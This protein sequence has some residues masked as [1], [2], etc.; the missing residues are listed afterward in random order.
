[1]LLLDRIRRTIRTYGLADSG[2]GVVAA[3]SGGSDSVALAHL[4]HALEAAGEL[5]L[6]GLAH[7]NHRLRPSSAEEERFC[8]EQAEALQ[9][10]FLVESGDVATRARRE[11]RS[12][13]DAARA[14]RHEF[15]ARALRHF[16]ANAIALGHTRDD[17]AETFLLRLLRGAGARGLAAMHP[18]RGAVIRPL[19]E[20]RRAELR[21]FLASRGLSFVRDES[22]DDVRIPRNR[23]RVELVPLLERR[24][25]PA[26]VDALADAAEIARGE[27]EWMEAR[28]ADLA[29]RLLRREGAT[30][31]LEAADVAALPAALG[32]ALL[33]R[34][35]T[36]VSAG[37]PVSFAHVERARDLARTDG[38]PVDGPG[39]RMQ[40]VG[41][42]LVLTSR[43]LAAAGKPEPFRYPL[44]V[45]GEVVVPEAGCALVAET[46][47]SVGTAA[48]A[49]L[50]TPAAVVAQL[51][52][53]ERPLA[54]RN[55]RP[56]DRFRPLGLRG[57]KK[58]QDYFVD[59]KVARSE[60]DAVPIVVDAA[61]RIVWVAGHAIADE[62][63]VTDPAQAVIILRLKVPGGPE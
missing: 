1:M 15:F 25:N 47:A 37:R 41:A 34:I 21:A 45:P 46:A 40:R 17:Q 55:R 4:L 24:F 52:R 58:L 49:V 11:R 8:R 61:D 7:F 33:W 59:R 43:G 13:E 50:G 54:V 6:V 22:N 53:I 57:R 27:W 63:R 51:D 32:R 2:T 62:F 12:L 42:E 48:R 10:P 31:R 36:D 16:G 39:L 38:P 19:L 14:S 9:R 5:R 29:A 18:R 56:G 44:P 60:R 23:V 35:L 30:W 3:L 20:C 28:A 26:V